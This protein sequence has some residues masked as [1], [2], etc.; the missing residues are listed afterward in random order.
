MAHRGRIDLV[1]YSLKPK[2]REEYKSA[3]LQFIEHCEEKKY[4]GLQNS[5]F[6]H[7]ILGIY[8]PRISETWRR[9]LDSRQ[10]RYVYPI[11]Y[12]PEVKGA[13]HCSHKEINGCALLGGSQK[14]IPCR[15]DLDLGI[16][17]YF[18]LWNKPKMNLAVLIMYD[19]LLRHHE[20]RSPMNRKVIVTVTVPEEIVL[21][22]SEMKNGKN[23]RCRGS[24][25][26]GNELL[27]CKLR[28]M[29][30]Q[31]KIVFLLSRDNFWKKITENMEEHFTLSSAGF[32]KA[33]HWLLHGG[34]TTNFMPKKLSLPE[35]KDRGRWKNDSTLYNYFQVAK[36][37]IEQLGWQK[38]Q[39]HF[40]NL[41]QHAGRYVIVEEVH[42]GQ[43]ELVTEC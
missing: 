9:W 26:L 5:R 10:Q 25:K 12:L 3:T 35:P 19:C 11:F 37:L 7:H 22:L 42:V 4:Y 8:A 43:Q 40:S 16:F 18:R 17:Y 29:A 6:W 1:A 14:T 31:D 38:R 33:H 2:T 23:Q 28:K 34:A 32:T 15:H 41:K 20:L 13:L 27:L 30:N 21:L 24:S 36:S 39:K